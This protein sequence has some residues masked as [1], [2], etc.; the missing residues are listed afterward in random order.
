[1]QA[2]FSYCFSATLS[3]YSVNILVAHVS[4][5]CRTA[6]SKLRRPLSDH[7][8]RKIQWL[9]LALSA[10][11]RKP[12]PSSS[13]CEILRGFQFSFLV[14]IGGLGCVCVVL[15]VSVAC[16]RSHIFRVFDTYSGILFFFPVI[17]CVCWLVGQS[18]RISEP[19]AFVLIDFNRDALV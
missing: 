9:A 11:A 10:S 4:G 7:S 19:T 16:M 17:V 12:R 5:D 1:M 18:A 13:S 6:V 3:W 14:A 8:G 2:H 15:S